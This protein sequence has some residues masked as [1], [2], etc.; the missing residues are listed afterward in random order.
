MYNYLLILSLHLI[1]INVTLSQNN[2]DESDKRLKDARGYIC[3]SLVG[4]E[5]PWCLSDIPACDGFQAAQCDWPN[6]AIYMKNLLDLLVD[7]N[8]CYNTSYAKDTAEWL[9]GEIS[10]PDVSGR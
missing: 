6:Q 9:D 2:C 5:T 10:D 3:S 8:T 4:Q 7:D 1:L